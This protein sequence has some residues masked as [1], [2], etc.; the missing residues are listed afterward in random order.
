MVP[1]RTTGLLHIL[2]AESVVCVPELCQRRTTKLRTDSCR[3]TA[4]CDRQQKCRSA[5]SDR[6]ILCAADTEP[7][8]TVVNRNL[9]T[10]QYNKTAPPTVLNGQRCA[11]HW[12]YS[13]FSEKAAE[14]FSVSPC[15]G[16]S[17]E[18]ELNTECDS[19]ASNVLHDAHAAV[20][21]SH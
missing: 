10:A 2:R 17:G 21:R 3:R 14:D 1:G 9:S 19:S 16:F 8:K 20:F 15:I 7:V 12:P 13:R 5:L 18:Q 11:D 4:S 6:N